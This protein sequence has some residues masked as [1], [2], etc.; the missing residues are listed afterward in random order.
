MSLS[1]GIRA[2]GETLQADY[3]V[4]RHECHRRRLRPLSP[5]QWLTALH[6]P[7][8]VYALSPPKRGWWRKLKRE[9]VAR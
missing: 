5:A 9:E 8:D 6:G 7:A 2:R 3:E 4:Y 1:P